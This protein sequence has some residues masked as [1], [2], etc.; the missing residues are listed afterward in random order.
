MRFERET[1]YDEFK[2]SLRELNEGIQSMAAIMNKGGAGTIWF[3]VRPD[4]TAIGMDVTEKT[5]RDVSQAIGNQIRPR[6]Y[7][8]V[9]GI[10]FDDGGGREVVRVDFR[11]DDPPY[12][13][14]GIY[15]V[16]VA[17]E[18]VQLEPAELRRMLAQ[19]VERRDPWDGR[20]S[21]R[22]I[23]DVDEQTLRD[24]VA[25]GNACGRIP[26]P[27][28][29]AGEVLEGLGLLRDG[30]LTNAA[31]V[32]FCKS[33]GIRLKQGVLESHS[34]TNILD[35]QQEEGTVFDL[36]RKADLYILNNTRRRLV[37]EGPG[38]RDEIPE[39]PREAVREA[40]YN[41]Y[42]HMD[43][44]R[45]D[46][47]IVDIYYD[48]VEILSP[49]WFIAGQDPEEHLSGRSKSPLTRNPL[50]AKTLYRSKEIEHYGTGIRRIKELCD[51]AGVG[52]EYRRTPDGTLL[53]FHRRD[54]FDGLAHEG[55][56]SHGEGINET[57][58]PAG[59]TINE[60]ISEGINEGIKLTRDENAVVR[61]MQLNPKVTYADVSTVT[62]FSESKTFRVIQALRERGVVERIGSRKTGSW[63]VIRG[64]GNG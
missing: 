64:D 36:V 44:T 14:K 51:E 4:G 57:V 45:W 41:A 17:D 3:G 56:Q 5:L 10:P 20:A 1:E 30:F 29:T 38:P 25:R 7:P 48:A 49:G 18:D 28:T 37:I 24:Y 33:R 21:E 58:N 27:Y 47:V 61:L 54:A 46:C 62:G 26:D 32:L 50:M 40:L 11:G 9:A 55:L 12:S 59:E 13:C 19:Q 52:V 6:I 60:G 31:D 43:W 34:R 23:S 15:R 35:L 63:R 16:R 53:V 42:C 2:A 8:T 39:I 22:C